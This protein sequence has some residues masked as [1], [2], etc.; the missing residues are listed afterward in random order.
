MMVLY[1]KMRFGLRLEGDKGGKSIKASFQIWNVLQP[2]SVQNTCVFSAFEAKDSPTN[3]HVAL[4]H[5]KQLQA[6]LWRYTQ[7][8]THTKLIVRCTLH[9]YR[10]N[11]IRLF[12]F[13]DY[14]FECR[15][16]GITG[17]QGK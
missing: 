3:L 11:R 7:T 13:G 2:N 16:F 15:M 12:L 6:I 5:M 1:L 4:D 14:E 10:G 17:A 9:T 8:S